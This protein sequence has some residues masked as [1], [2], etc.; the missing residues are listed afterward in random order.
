MIE[1]N[2]C[3]L[4]E[5]EQFDLDEVAQLYV[6]PQVRM[7]LGGAIDEEHLLQM[8]LLEVMKRVEQGAHYFVIRTIDHQEFMGLVSLDPY[9]DGIH[10]EISYEFLPQWWGAGYATEAI[11][12][13]IDYGLYALELPSLVAET[14]T[15]NKA[16][17]M[18][19]ERVGMTLQH[20]LHRFGAEQAVY[21][22]ERDR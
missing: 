15:A 3:R 12:R 4:T 19:L 13:V 22:I 1:T 8:K 21:R 7:Y 16:S 5:I 18:L 2:R 14:Q 20:Q 10:T 11:E 9:H 6:N 17:C